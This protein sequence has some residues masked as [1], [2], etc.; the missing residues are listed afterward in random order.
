MTPPLYI[1]SIPFLLFVVL[2]V[3]ACQGK[4][5]Q[6]SSPPQP[7]VSHKTAKE[8]KVLIPPDV[9][10]TWGA[11]KIAVIDKTRATENIYTVPIG[12]KS[13]I[14]SSNI[15]ITAEAF[16]PSF[17]ME[18]TTMTSASNELNNP[19]VKVRITDNGQPIFVGWLFSR[20]PTTHAVTHPK[21][22][23]TL[24]GAVSSSK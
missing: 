14:P 23:F 15:T 4:T 18:G 19:G 1:K 3:T 13:R 24:V 2:F 16:L 9:K 22:G 10:K 7:N 11:V 20:F 5:E 8:K 6:P 12:G 17:V 21:F